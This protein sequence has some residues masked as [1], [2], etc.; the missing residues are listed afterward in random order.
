MKKKISLTS[1]AALALFAAT[2]AAGAADLAPPPPPPAPEIRPSVTDW[3]GPY[4]GG[5]FGGTCMETHADYITYGY[6]DANGNGQYDPGERNTTPSE[7]LPTDM[8]GCGYGGG[9]VAGYNY[10]MDTIVFG[11]EGEWTWGSY[12]GR[13][14]AHYYDQFG[15][16]HTQFDHYDIDWQANIRLRVGYL[17][18]ENTLAYLTG[19][20]SWLRGTLKDMTTGTSFSET[21]PGY[22]IGGGIEHAITENIHL[23]GEY[24]FSSYKDKTYGRYCDTCDIAVD[25]RE[26]MDSFHTF[27]VGIT[28]NFP[29]A[30][31]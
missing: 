10:Q 14:V 9:F 18:S 21:H 26:K 30:Q 2:T 15:N 19:G 24:L 7:V 11:L 27:R 12:T 3:T 29:V 17:L 28:W 31:W 5:V 13:H 6:T 23:R 8:N 22:V 20:F 1:L 16:R 25:V 4:V